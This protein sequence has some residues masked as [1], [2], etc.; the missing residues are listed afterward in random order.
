MNHENQLLEALNKIREARL[1][2]NFG[3]QEDNQYIELIY[4]NLEEMYEETTQLS[5]LRFRNELAK[6]HLDSAPKDGTKILVFSTQYQA[7]ELAF[8][9]EGEWYG[10]HHSSIKGNRLDETDVLAWMP[11]PYG[12][13]E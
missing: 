3:Y 8:Y 10:A 6:K 4:Q 1:L 7:W 9:Q 12:V 13:H 2:L 11:Q 5:N